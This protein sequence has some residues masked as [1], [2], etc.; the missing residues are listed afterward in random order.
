MPTHP[1]GTPGT[2]GEKL[3]S[4]GVQVSTKGMVRRNDKPPAP[5]RYNNWEKGIAGEDRPGG[6]R[7]PYLDANGG[8][9]PI[10]EFT[11]GKHNAGLKA[12]DQARR[13]NAQKDT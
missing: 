4:K 5:H 10:K 6:T 2:Y 7:M 13:V 1:V 3:R 8:V 12:L 9:I 11:E